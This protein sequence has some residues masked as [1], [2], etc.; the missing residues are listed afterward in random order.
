VGHGGVAFVW[1]RHGSADNVFRRQP[2]S[3]M[4]RRGRRGLY[5]SL[6]GACLHFRKHLSVLSSSPTAPEGHAARGCSIAC[7]LCTCTAAVCPQAHVVTSSIE[8]TLPSFVCVLPGFNADAP[9]RLNARASGVRRPREY[10]GRSTA[11]SVPIRASSVQLGMPRSISAWPIRACCANPASRSQ[12]GN[13]VH[14][15]AARSRFAVSAA[16]DW[17]SNSVPRSSITSS[18]ALPACLHNSPMVKDRTA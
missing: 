8:Q 5:S 18:G 3:L 2:S 11:L 6:Y 15:T 4:Q 1:H 13:R 7:R 14:L 9:G 16:S 12:R 10:Y 17:R